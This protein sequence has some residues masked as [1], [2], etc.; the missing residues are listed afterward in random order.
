MRKEIENIFGSHSEKKKLKK[1]LE[2]IKGTMKVENIDFG[3]GNIEVEGFKIK[4]NVK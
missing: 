2:D 1:T 4:L 3:K